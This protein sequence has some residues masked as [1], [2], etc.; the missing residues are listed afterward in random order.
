MQRRDVRIRHALQRL[1]CVEARVRRKADARDRD[2]A[3][4]Q[5]ADARRVGL[6]RDERRFH[7]VLVCTGTMMVTPSTVTAL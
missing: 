7:A 4:R 6:G 3:A 1:Q 5:Q 2:G